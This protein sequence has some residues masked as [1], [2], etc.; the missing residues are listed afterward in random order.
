MTTATSFPRM[1]KHAPHGGNHSVITKDLL[2]ACPTWR[3][4]KPFEKA[5]M[6]FRRRWSDKV[7]KVDVALQ[8]DYSDPGLTDALVECNGGWLWR[9]AGPDELIREINQA[10]NEAAELHQL[11]DVSLYLCRHEILE[12]DPFEKTHDCRC[13]FDFGICNCDRLEELESMNLAFAIL[14]MH[15]KRTR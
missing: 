6:E 2:R 11:G 12:F 1:C 3:H 7:V 10:A 15:A 9:V 14:S 4:I 8:P 13:S 5:M